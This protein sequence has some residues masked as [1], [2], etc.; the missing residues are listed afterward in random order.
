VI[1]LI[2]YNKSWIGR[3]VKATY[4]LNII[5]RFGIIKSVIYDGRGAHAAET[6]EYFKNKYNMS[7]VKINRE[8]EYERKAITESNYRIAVSK[9][10][11]SY[12]RRE[13][14]YLGENHVVIPCTLNKTFLEKYPTPKQITSKRNELGYNE[15]D[16]VLAF[17]GSVAGWQSFHLLDKFFCEVLRKQKNLKILMFSKITLEKLQSYQQFPDRIQ[18]KWVKVE[19]VYLSLSICD[20]GILFRENTITNKVS[21]PVKFAE[22]LASGLKVLITENIGDYS[23]MVFNENL[24]LVISNSDE[25]LHQKDFRKT[26]YIEKSSLNNF[27]QKYFKKVTFNEE[28]RQVLYRQ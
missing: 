24:G 10:L 20:Y 14:N 26:T 11:V 22:Y 5:A 27:A 7:E 13:Y 16:V 3:G 1:S 25:Y 9:E 23:S 21:S 18:K 19:E 8:I 12:W 2:F 17:V 15:D 28:Y 6:K 4:L